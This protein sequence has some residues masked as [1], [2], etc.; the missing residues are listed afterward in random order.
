MVKFLLIGDLAR[1]L[2]DVAPPSAEIAA[3]NMAAPPRPS[4]GSKND[5][6]AREAWGAA[7]DKIPKSVFALAAWHLASLA[8]GDGRD[9]KAE[10]RFAYEIA[11]LTRGDHLPAAQGRAALRHLPEP[12]NPDADDDDDDA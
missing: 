12:F 1:H 11:V 3:R 5:D 2:P 7:Y 4:R 8:A 6:A 10:A 9:G